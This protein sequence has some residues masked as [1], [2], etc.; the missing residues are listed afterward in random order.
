MKYYCPQHRENGRLKKN[1]V[2]D[3]NLAMLNKSRNVAQGFRLE[4]LLSE[5]TLPF[6]NSI[7][8][9]TCFDLIVS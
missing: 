1:V 6:S 8:L 2:C 3:F 9:R 4:E 7:I 5:P